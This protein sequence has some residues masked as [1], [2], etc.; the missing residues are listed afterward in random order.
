MPAHET[1]LHLDGNVAAGWLAEVFHGDITTADVTCIAC[2]R[3]GPVG[4][5]TAYGLHMGV[6]L[7]CPGCDQ[8]LIRLTHIHDQYWL[9]LRGATTLRLAVPQA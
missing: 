7:R 3:L 1:D 6:I 4:T 8:A 2:G 9:D 5:L